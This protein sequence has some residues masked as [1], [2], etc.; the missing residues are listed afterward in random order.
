M[1]TLSFPKPALEPSLEQILLLERARLFSA[2]LRSISDLEYAELV[3][4]EV[5]TQAQRRFRFSAL[6]PSPDSW[7]RRIAQ[8]TLKDGSY[9]ASLEF[10]D[11]DPLPL[12]FAL[13]HPALTESH[14]L[15]LSLSLLCG[16]Q[17]AD[18]RSFYGER[19]AIVQERRARRAITHSLIPDVRSNH[20]RYSHRISSMQ[21]L[22]FRTYRLLCRMGRGHAC[23][24][25]LQLTDLLH[26][27]DS[28]AR[29][30]EGLL[31]WMNLQRARSSSWG[32]TTDFRFEDRSNWDPMM[33]AQGLEYLNMARAGDRVGP[34][35]LRAEV[36]ACHMVAPSWEESNWPKLVELYRALASLGD[37]FARLRLA[38]AL[39][40]VEGPAAGLILL[41]QF[42]D[43]HG[44]QVALA[45]ADLLSQ[46]GRQKEAF[47]SYR[48]ALQFAPRRIRDG[49]IQRM[50]FCQ[51]EGPVIEA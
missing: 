24:F 13:S 20:G 2:L 46:M 7:L 47:Q 36:A 12:V 37:G 27:V 16:L 45:R 38:E 3:L 35:A 10:S 6:P 30:T 43:E 19:R 22:L 51:Q 50:A 14:Q 34:F 41:E 42:G 21:H 4:E 9:A 31:A 18:L 49:L 40:F 8:R 17:P 23:D 26:S 11:R 15:S 48:H 25:L 44:H 32:A 5:F 29:E 33:I 1:P 28:G 39:G